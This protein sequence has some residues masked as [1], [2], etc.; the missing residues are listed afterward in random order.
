MKS[1]L[2]IIATGASFFLSFYTDSLFQD[3][4]PAAT[5]GFIKEMKQTCQ[6]KPDTREHSYI[7]CEC[8][9]WSL[10]KTIQTHEK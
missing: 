4:E 10:T 1:L 5:M 8:S 7:L 2:L 9:I 3:I 6:S